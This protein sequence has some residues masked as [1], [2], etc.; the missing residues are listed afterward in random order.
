MNKNNNLSIT[1]DLYT[2]SS[3]LSGTCK[4]V[5]VLYVPNS[6]CDIIT[7]IMN[8][9]FLLHSIGHIVSLSILPP[10]AALIL[11]IIAAAGIQLDWG[12]HS[13]ITD[14]ILAHVVFIG[15]YATSFIVGSILTMHIHFMKATIT[16]ALGQLLTYSVIYITDHNDHGLLRFIGI[17]LVSFLFFFLY[18]IAHSIQ[19]NT[20]L[21]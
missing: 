3:V 11:L 5:R 7:F 18:R 17:T 13:A 16:I 19:K 8:L 2:F 20:V 4:D 21:S 1:V 14:T 9:S 12:Q 15:P 6:T 10:I